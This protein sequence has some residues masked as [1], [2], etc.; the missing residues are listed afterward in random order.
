MKGTNN[1]DGMITYAIWHDDVYP[2]N[3]LPFMGIHKK[4]KREYV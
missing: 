2:G 1:N 3:S 4:S